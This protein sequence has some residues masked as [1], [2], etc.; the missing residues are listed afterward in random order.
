MREQLT[1]RRSMRLWQPMLAQGLRDDFIVTKF[2]LRFRERLTVE[3]HLSLMRASSVSAV[4]IHAIVTYNGFDNLTHYYSEMSAMGD[5]TAFQRKQS[6]SHTK[7]HTTAHSNDD[8]GRIGQVSIPF[9]VIH[10]LDDPLISWRT[11][12]Y[13]PDALVRSGSGNIMMLL[14][15]SGGHVGWPLGLNPRKEGWR[16]MHDAAGGFVTSV[17]RVKKGLVV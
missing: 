13:D 12:G 7:N 16:W 14:T 15:K 9:C 17:D 8:I 2:D 4:D 3:Q 5:T 1:F 10:S 6:T 11:M